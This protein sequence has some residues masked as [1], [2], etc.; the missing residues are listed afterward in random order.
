MWGIRYLLGVG[1]SA[2]NRPGDTSGRS[3]LACAHLIFYLEK[4]S[5]LPIS[6][7][8]RVVYAAVAIPKS[9]NKASMSIRS[10]S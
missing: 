2:R 9:V 10:F 8:Q 1:D 3:L 4:A 7:R 6:D 5:R